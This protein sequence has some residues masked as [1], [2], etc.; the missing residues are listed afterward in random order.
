MT[1]FR[2]LDI[3]RTVIISHSRIIARYWWVFRL[4]RAGFRKRLAEVTVSSTAI[5]A[6]VLWRRTGDQP[7]RREQQCDILRIGSSIVIAESARSLS[8]IL[9][10]GDM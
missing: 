10:G 7:A 5:W 9:M 8:N 6:R 2:S 4:S 1:S 3:L